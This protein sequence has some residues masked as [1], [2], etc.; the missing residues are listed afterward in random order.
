MTIL[1][2]WSSLLKFWGSKPKLLHNAQACGWSRQSEFKSKGWSTIKTLSKPTHLSPL[3]WWVSLC[4]S[5]YSDTLQICVCDPLQIESNRT[6]MLVSKTEDKKG[7]FTWQ[8]SWWQTCTGSEPASH[9]N[10]SLP[11]NRARLFIN[12]ELS[13][14]TLSEDNYSWFIELGKLG[15]K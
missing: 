10:S 5:D 13:H 1:H 14:Q 7:F 8:N 9:Q 11:K 12:K 4:L 6:T 15:C 2:E 3:L